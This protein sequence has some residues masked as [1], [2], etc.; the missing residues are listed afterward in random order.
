MHK[1]DNTGRLN[2]WIDN[3][4][5]GQIRPSEYV[6]INLKKG[7][8]QFKALHLDVVNMKSLH[9]VVIDEKTEIIKIKPNVTSNKLEITNELPKNFG[10]FK[11]T[12]KR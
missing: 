1:I 9:Y 2:V 12:E 5:L 10:K 4:P 8:Y 3:K 7:Q 11:Y 6:I